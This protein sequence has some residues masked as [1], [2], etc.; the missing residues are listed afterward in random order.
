MD[1]R[2]R[3]QAFAGFRSKLSQPVE[4]CAA[5]AHVQA[6]EKIP[7]VKSFNKCVNDASVGYLFVFK[8][9]G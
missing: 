1:G 3:R 2:V 6:Q 7:A 8:I 4:L 9:L 5:S